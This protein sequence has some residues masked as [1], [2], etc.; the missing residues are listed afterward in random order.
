[1]RKEKVSER[2]RQIDRQTERKRERTEYIDNRQTIKQTVKY[3]FC[4]ITHQ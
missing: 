3:K 2:A 1:M 4:N